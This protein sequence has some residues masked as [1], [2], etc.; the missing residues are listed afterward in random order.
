MKKEKKKILVAGTF[1]IIHA[2]HIYLINEAAKL[3]DV[4][5][6]VATDKNR[7]LFS[8][9]RPILSQEQRVEIIKN[10]KNVRDA[11]LGRNDND[12]L[13]TVEEINPDMIL[14]GPDQKYSIDTIKKGLKQRGLNHIEV[15]RLQKYYEK[16][17]LHSSSLIKRKII[18]SYEKNVK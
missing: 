13:K 8:G 12:T 4:Y 7:E 16:Y 11:R 9:K 17:E 10:L 3:G 5:V 6:V 1:D 15:K 14:L 2:G 18:E